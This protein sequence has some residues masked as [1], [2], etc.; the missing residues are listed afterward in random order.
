MKKWIQKVF[1]IMVIYG[2]TSCVDEINL[3]L[4]ESNKAIVIEAWV[5]NVPGETYV[6][7]YKTS[8]FVS[9][10]VNPAYEEVPV[11]SVVVQQSEGEDIPFSRIGWNL[12][13]QPAGFESI[14]GRGYRLVVETVEGEIFESTWEIMPPFVE[15]VDIKGEAFEK[16][17]MIT[18]GQSLFLQNRTFADVQAQIVDPG[19][20]EL[21]YLI[22]SSGITELYT[23]ANVDNC[24][25]TCYQ[26]VPNIFA[27]MNVTSNE[28]FQGRNFGLS[29]GEIPLSS[30]GKFFVSTNVK[31][32]NKSSYEYLN[33]VD[34]QQR[35]SG[36][37]FDPA[38]S[39]IKGNI[40]KRGAENEIVLGGFFL[41]Q[42]SSF[43][44]VLFRTD[45]RNQSLNLNH[46]LDA[47]PFVNGD[48]REVYIDATPIV[49]LPFRP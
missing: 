2:I 7:I 17:V 41:F 14:P 28:P 49:P 18:T 10:A 3:K 19:L 37:I 31:V 44:K 33:Q 45:I 42:E 12:F 32:V 9:G 11:E 15:V 22:E 39:R 21:G 35:N 20:G 43:E 13:R 5:G 30:I 34:Q 4:N 25:C 8:P 24:A 38:P 46:A 48:C 16:Q 1:L 47:L 26:N 6:K 23:T 27:G 29:L 36:S 40:K